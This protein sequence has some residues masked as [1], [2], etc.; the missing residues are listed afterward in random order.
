MIKVEDLRNFTFLSNPQTNP[1]RTL[2]AFVVSNSDYEQNK[3]INKIY[4]FDGQALKPLTEA[5]NETDF[6]F[7]D[8][9]NILFK[10]PE[11]NRYTAQTEA[12]SK[13]PLTHYYRINVD[14]GEAAYAFSIPLDVE[15][16]WPLNNNGKF[17]VLASYDLNYPDLWQKTPAEQEEICRHNEET[18]FCRQIHEIP[19]Q[20][21][22]TG[23]LYNRR[24]ALFFFDAVSEELELIGEDYPNYVIKWVS[25]NNAKTK[26]LFSATCYE[27]N[28]EYRYCD[29][30]KLYEVD[31]ENCIITPLYEQLNQQL[32]DGFYVETVNQQHQASGHEIAV[33]ISSDTSGYGLNENNYFYVYDRASSQLQ[34]ISDYEIIYGN[35]VGSDV[36]YGCCQE[37][38]VSLNYLDLIE[39]VDCRSTLQ[40]FFFVE[41][42]VAHKITLK[43][44]MLVDREGAV[45]AAFSLNIAPT[46]IAEEFASD[47]EC[48]S[49]CKCEN[50]CKC[51]NANEC[52]CDSE[53]KCGCQRG[54]PCSCECDCDDCECE[55]ENECKCVSDCNCAN[56]CDC[57]GECDCD[58]C[59]CNDCKCENNCK[60]NNANECNCDSE[61]KC[62]CQSGEPCSC[63]CNCENECKCVSDC[64]CANDCNCNGECDCDD[65]DC[66]DCKCEN[67]CK[68]GCKS[69]DTCTCECKCDSECKCGCQSGEP[70]S[71]ECDCGN[72]CKCVSD[73]NCANDCDCN[74]ECDCDDCDCNDCKFENDCKCSCKSGDTC[75][76][77]CKCDCDDCKC[78]CDDCDCD[79]C[80]CECECDDCDDCDCGNECKCESDC[81]CANDCDCN[82]DN[83]CN[84]G[85][86]CKC[87]CQSGEPCS[88][89]QNH[90][91]LCIIGFYQQNRSEIYLVHNPKNLQRLTYFNS[92]NLSTVK[93]LPLSITSRFDREAVNG[94]VLLPPDFRQEARASYPLILDIHGG[95]KTV[96]G[97]TYYHEMQVW[98]NLGFVVC[99]TNPHGSDGR[100][101][102]FADIRGAYGQQDYD[103]LM[104]FLDAVLKTYPQIDSK[105]LGVTGG[106]YGGFMTNWII[107]HT[108]RFQAACTQ[109]SISNWLSFYGTSDIGYLFATDQNKVKDFSLE[110]Q[111]TLWEHSPLH[112]INNAVTPTLIIH[113]DSDYRCPYEQGMQLH[114]ALTA[115]GVPNKLCVF[116]EENHELSRSGR[117]K[118]REQRL[119]LITHWFLQYLQAD[120]KELIQKFAEKCHI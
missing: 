1:S 39:T 74:S 105:R 73:C 10:T 35:S 95:P 22:G 30:A 55:C 46:V 47:C 26:A 29:F 85:S 67:D 50:N 76:C 20:A 28:N 16:L 69:G 120:N 62:G 43:R 84:C 24:S 115:L 18:A 33:L 23:Y 87:G 37:K 31:L 38:Y 113:S 5:G 34:K 92:Q 94:Y 72:E 36:A 66:N 91:S 90:S 40:R 98:A 77:E 7:E 51:N 61:C 14:G 17:L 8:E 102:K 45:N 80:E 83:E 103:D 48:N 109:R 81:N 78:D 42:K 108:K 63:E 96:Y 58:D 88:C 53:C 99:C 15:K 82:S 106:S 111:K 3:Y 60:C 21:N 100:G 54:E 41:D 32:G 65:C 13:R 19:F 27:G 104:D 117:I 110:D 101:N 68:C 71:C 11:K 114:T 93:P 2:A 6:L 57:N 70:C 9:K 64:N 75:T 97:S 4:T 86:D 119:N 49:D 112:Y 116:H 118:A 79:D 89:R 52:N 107:T 59:D 12:E 25:L 44:K 56:D